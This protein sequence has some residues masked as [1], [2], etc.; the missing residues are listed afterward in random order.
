M[1]G[2][3]TNQYTWRELHALYMLSIGFE[4]EAD[5]SPKY[6]IAPTNQ[7][8]VILR[9]AGERRAVLMRWGLVPSWARE[10]GKFSTF[11][12]RADGIATKPMFRGAWAADRRCLIPASSFFEWR[13]PDKQPFAIALGNRGAMAF[14]G[15]WDEWTPKGGQPLRSCTIITCAPNT[16][17]APLHDRMPVILPRDAYARWLSPDAIDPAALED[18]FEPAPIGDWVLT[19][20]SPLVNKPANDLPACI[21]PS[22]DDAPA[23]GS[24]F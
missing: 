15:L 18:L 12:A 21:E 6:N 16:L 13:K 22:S 19:P 5:W 4:R 3:F 14:A 8:P 7:I 17:L 11:N 20:V 10:I 2:R 1:C 9:E 24:L 23:Q